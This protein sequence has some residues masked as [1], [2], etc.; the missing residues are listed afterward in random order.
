MLDSTFIAPMRRLAHDLPPVVPAAV[1]VF[2]ATFGVAAA[3][4]WN[5]PGM[6]WG[7]DTRRMLEAGARLRAGASPYADPS[8]YYSPLAALLAAPLSVLP[9]G[10]VAAAWAGAKVAIVAGA[11]WTLTSRASMP[12]RTMAVLA[13]L[14][15]L[16]VIEDVW[17]GNV[18]TLIAAGMAWVVWGRRSPG[19]GILLGL[20]L[21]TGPKPIAL[22][23]VVWMLA[24]RREALIGTIAS[25]AFTTSIALV[26]TG[27]D[28]FVDFVHA[29][30]D[31]PSRMVTYAGNL[32]PA[33]VAPQL[34]VPAGILAMGCFAWV[35]LRRGEVA[36]LI[37]AVTS[38]V[39][40]TAVAGVYSMVPLLVAGAAAFP[41]AP[42]RTL[43]FGPAVQVLLGP[44]FS[45]VCT[46]ILAVSLTLDRR[47][48]PEAIVGAASPDRP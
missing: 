18:S 44:L 12:A 26:L 25:G 27:P 16:P 19:S 23:F 15:F 14:T 17:Q 47:A 7:I 31:G 6:D 20:V 22:P 9:G 34:A 43:A 11:A 2:I 36:G 30:L 4:R 32:V 21:A 46:A 33:A 35:L 39:F 37:W 1:A 40:I 45:I 24:W 38:G 28:M 13:S 29:L 8:Y 5:L 41:L 42:R 10:W 48:V 3:I